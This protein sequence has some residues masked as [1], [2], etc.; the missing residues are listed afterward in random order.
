MRP[1]LGAAAIGIALHLLGVALLIALGFESST[2]FHE[3]PTPSRRSSIRTP[4]P[5]N[6]AVVWSGVFNFLGVLASTGAVA[7]GVIRCAPG[8]AHPSG[9]Q[10]CRVRHGLRPA[11]RGDHLELGTWYFGIPN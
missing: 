5:P 11:D 10:P 3:P 4:L 8:R 7:F 6:V 1:G 2:A 9:R